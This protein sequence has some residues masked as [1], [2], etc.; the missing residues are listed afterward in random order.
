MT[1]ECTNA[2]GSQENTWF[3]I[4]QFFTGI[5]SLLRM[6]RKSYNRNLAEFSGNLVQLRERFAIVS[7]PGDE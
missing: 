4:G 6:N 1:Q 3:R 2:C 7:L 5:N